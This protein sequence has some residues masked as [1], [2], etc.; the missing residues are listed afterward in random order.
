MATKIAMSTEDIAKDMEHLILLFGDDKTT[1][2][3]L[4]IAHLIVMG[5]RRGKATSYAVLVIE[6]AKLR[7]E[8]I[9]SI[10]GE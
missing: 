10:W 9:T 3:A 4:I 2:K 7:K 8:G 5:W 6:Y 1:M